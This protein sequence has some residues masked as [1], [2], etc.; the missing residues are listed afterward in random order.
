MLTS[1]LLRHRIEF[2]SLLIEEVARAVLTLEEIF[3]VL[4]DQ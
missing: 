4:A 3:G 2:C 1:D